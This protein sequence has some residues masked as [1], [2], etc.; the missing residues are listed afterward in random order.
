MINSMK[1][2]V[3]IDEF[4][5]MPHTIYLISVQVFQ[6]HVGRN[7]RGNF[8]SFDRSLSSSDLTANSFKV[9]SQ[10]LGFPFASR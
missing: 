9:I 8:G 7:V 2:L 4:I 3:D 10:I 5:L 6:N 1:I